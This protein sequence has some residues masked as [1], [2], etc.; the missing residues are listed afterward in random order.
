MLREFGRHSEAIDALKV[1]LRIHDESTPDLQLGLILGEIGDEANFLDDIAMANEY[2][3]R[4]LAI[5]EKA[6]PGSLA[7]ARALNRLG[8]NAWRA[9]DPEAAQRYALK[10]LEI[11]ER[12]DPN[13]IHVVRAL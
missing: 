3:L 7:E 10:T 1:A 5:F 2:Q 12:L 13:S 11:R 6:A 4:A 9:H 8:L